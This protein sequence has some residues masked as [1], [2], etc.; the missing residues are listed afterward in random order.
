[1]I[2]VTV[3][4]HEQPFDRLVQAAAPLADHEPLL[5]QHGTSGV[6]VGAGGE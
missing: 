5:V 4:T 3:G 2:V 6:P 1:M